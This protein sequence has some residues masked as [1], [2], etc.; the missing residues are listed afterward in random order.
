MSLRLKLVVSLVLLSVGATVAIGTWSYIATRNRLYLEVNRS[1]DHAH[2]EAVTP[3]MHGEDHVG[4]TDGD[5]TA[6]S[7]RARPRSFEQIVVQRLDQHGT[8]V[9]AP[10]A[11]ALPVDARDRTIAAITTAGVFVR[12]DVRVDNE[13]FRVDTIALGSTLGAV[14]VARSLAET[15][16]LLDSLRNRALE[17]TL[18]VAIL[19]ALCGW[20]VAHRVTRRLVR[21]TATAEHVAATGVLDVAAP[22]SGTDEAG[23]LAGAFNAMLEALAASRS[24]QQQLVQDAGHDLRTPLTSLRTNV[25][26]LRRMD[27]LTPEERD[28]I[29]D[30]LDGETKELSELVNELVELATD[31]R[32]DEPV[33]RVAL[34][35][36][37]EGAVARAMRR[38]DAPIEVDCDDSVVLGRRNALDRAVANLLDNAIKFGPPDTPIEVAC[39]RGRIAVSDRGTGIPPDAT[40]RIFERFVRTDEARS[41][42][43]SGLGLAIVRQLVEQHGGTVF[44]ENRRGGGASIGFQIPVS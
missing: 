10:A 42:P 9:V 11:G 20:F 21:L 28:R 14:Q 13:P 7:G 31:Q 44:A 16:R 25:R 26:V 1:L 12:R 6:P 8:V 39:R 35:E 23:R 41:R 34:S 4:T 18:L 43:G 2:D 33:E 17:A 32:D 3:L 19:A 24:A 37:I 40:T 36:V 27:E 29:L 15:Q 22:V 30:D 38:T 5:E